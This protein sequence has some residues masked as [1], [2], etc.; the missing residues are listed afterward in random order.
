LLDQAIAHGAGEVREPDVRAMLGV[1]DRDHL[2]RIV[3]ALITCDGGA[4]MTEADA[5]AAGGNDCGPVLDE[6]AALY[7]RIAVAQL[8][9]GAID[10]D[11]AP[12]IASYAAKLSPEDVQLAYQICV[13]GRADLELAPDEATG[14]S[15][16]L[17]RLLAFEPATALEGG[18]PM[19]AVPA[20]GASVA[21]APTAGGPVAGARAS[22][23][24]AARASAARA[25]A[26]APGMPATAKLRLPDDPAQWAA[27]IAGLGLTGMARQLA[28]QSELRS[29]RGNALSLAVPATHRHLAD[30]AYA[31][32][33][34]TA[35]DAATGR[36]W[37]L[38][39]EI[40]DAGS[41][42]LAAQERR[43]RDEAQAAGEAAF[44]D[45]PFVRD[46]LQRFD[47][48][49]RVETIEHSADA[50]PPQPPVTKSQERS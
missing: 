19:F 13:Q 33:L 5:I 6:L 4:L 32:K 18:A 48:T 15:M 41:A 44:R 36:K 16:T 50:Q 10:G 38:A 25:S 34:K 31:D 14:L 2:Y 3:D 8:V 49:V 1:V 39:F 22:G 17:L 28:A 47:G 35:L 37:L 29:I 43:Q 7:H 27:F 9:P 21:G 46:L 40:G 42:S 20:A 30:K 45:E 26:T 12:R 23:A 24:S 11:E